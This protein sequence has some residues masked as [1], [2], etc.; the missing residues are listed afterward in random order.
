MKMEQSVP[1]RRHIKFRRR[2]IAQ[3]KTYNR[4]MV[5]GNLEEGQEIA[6][7]NTRVHFTAVWTVAE[8]C[9]N[10]ARNS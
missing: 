3:K 8:K 9:Y 4:S 5:H 10:I 1:K 2:G 7:R 6:A